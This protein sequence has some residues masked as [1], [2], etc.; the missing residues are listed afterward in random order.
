M[1][2]KLRSKIAKS[3]LTNVLHAM[4]L[5]H[6]LFHFCHISLHVHHIEKHPQ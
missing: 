6:H 3:G 1:K 5:I 2:I 4:Y